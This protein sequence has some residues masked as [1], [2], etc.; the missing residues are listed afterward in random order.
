MQ[1]ELK[2]HKVNTNDIQKDNLMTFTYF[3]K[4]IDVKQNGTQLIVEDVD[5]KQQIK[6]NGKDIIEN[7]SSADLY[8][9]E[10]KSNKTTIAG[11]LT[12]LYNKPF[13]V[14]FEKSNGDE[15]VLRGRL[16]H[17]EPLLGRSMVED[18]DV[19]S[20]NNVRQVDH[21]T[22]KWLIVDGVKY[23]VS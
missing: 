4:V 3:V 15:R 2:K 9:E 17:P 7:A 1:E 18:L 8:S 23:V 14:S 21:R 11:I 12:S 6:I 22:I 10:I 13:K 16:I 5:N 20:D 19:S